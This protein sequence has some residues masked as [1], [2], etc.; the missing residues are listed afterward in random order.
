MTTR[1]YRA[2]ELHKALVRIGEA[3]RTMHDS[4][5]TT[6]DAALDQRRQQIEAAIADAERKLAAAEK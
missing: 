6:A 3:H 5:H 2:D 1:D 4:A